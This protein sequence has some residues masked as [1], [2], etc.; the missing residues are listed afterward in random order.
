[1]AKKSK[2]YAPER[3]YRLGTM[4]S[5]RFASRREAY[6][7]SIHEI[8]DMGIAPADL[9]HHAPAFAG[10][11]NLARY[12]AL[13]EAYKMTLPIAG[14]I[15]EAGIWKGTCTIFFAKLMRMFE[16][17]SNTLVHGFDWFKGARLEGDE[18]HLVEDGL[19]AASY[20]WVTKLVA[21]QGLDDVVRIHDLDLANALPNFFASHQH[22]QFKLVFL[23]CGLYKV[24]RACLEQF[25][26]RLTPGGLLVLDN[27][28]HETAPGE[29]RAVSEFLPGKS[30][31][32][33]GFANQP[34]GY[35]IKD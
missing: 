28:N 19:Y 14:H 25:W 24:V 9:I 31:R 29:S 16:P 18:A 15:A 4:E 3:G 5:Q 6:W 2:H 11:I 34:T 35:I 27:F 32:S 30:I 26:P 10:H 7:Q 8:L 22:L 1:M 17:D 33:F 13:Y 23:D 20:E 12:L 21:V